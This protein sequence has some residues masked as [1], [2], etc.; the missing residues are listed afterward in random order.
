[1]W[2]DM[3]GRWVHDAKL[4]HF[5]LYYSSLKQKFQAPKDK[6]L[7]LHVGTKDGLPG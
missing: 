6:S 4:A 3:I 1:M 7:N 5:G 2:P